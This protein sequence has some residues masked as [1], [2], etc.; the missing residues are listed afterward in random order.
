MQNYG[1]GNNY[2]PTLWDNYWRIYRIDVESAIQIALNRVPG[3]VVKV[4]LDYDDGLLIYEIYIRT[5]QGIYEV[6]INAIT[7]QILKVEKE[8]NYY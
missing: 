5:M 4:E 2:Y 6:N 7:G 8:N 3:Q 1:Y